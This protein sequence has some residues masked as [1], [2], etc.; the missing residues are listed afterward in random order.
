[1]YRVQ[2]F[3]RHQAFAMVK[4]YDDARVDDVGTV[5]KLVAAEE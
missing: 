5:A 3:S 1:L 2:T 4:R